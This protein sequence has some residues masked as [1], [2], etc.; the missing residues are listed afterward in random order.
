M[1][2][3]AHL[4]LVLHNHQPIGNFDGVFEAA[5]Q[6]SYLPFLD[7]FEPYDQLNISLH[8]SGPLLM[9]LAE[10]HPE[11]IDRV[12]ALVDVGRIEIIGGPQYEPIMTMLPARDR[13]G[14]IQ[15]YASW[16]RRT[17]GTHP[18]GMWTPERVWE[19]NLTSSVAQAG[20]QYTVLD[21][22]HFRAA[23]V[24]EQDMTGYFLTEDDGQTLRIF[25]GSERLRYTIPFQ[26]AADTIAYC[27]EVAERS[28]GAVLTFGD[29]GEK[30]GTWPDTKAHVYEGGWLR[31]F[32]DALTENAEWLHTITLAEAVQKTSAVGKVYLPDCSYREMTEWSLPVEQQTQLD[33]VVHD[34]EN[35]PRWPA[36]S[37]FVRGGYWRNFK[38]KYAEANEMYARMMDIS[39]RLAE[40][41]QDGVDAG[42]LASALDH[43]YRGQ[44]NCPYWHGAF[45]GI[46]LPHLR[47]AVYQ[48]LIEADNQ[49]ERATREAGASWAEATAEDYDFDGLHEVRL[50]SDKLVAIVAPG[51]GG[52]ITELDVRE[53]AHNLLAT[54]QRRPEAYHRKVLTGPSAAGDAVA[55]IHDR[56][57]FKQEGLDERLQYDR[58]P[59][60]SMMDHFYDEN[61]TLEAV[62]RGDA[63]ERGDFVD[64]PFEAK[65]RRA[66]DRVQL[67]MR[68]DGNAWGIPITI[69]KALTVAAGSDTIEITY[70]LE[71]LPP[72]NPLHFGI[73][74]NFAGLPAGADDRFFSDAEGNRL[75]QLGQ[76]QD[77]QEA[78]GLS[79]TDQWL[80]IEVGLD[81]DRPSGIWAF[82]VETVSQSEGGFELVHQSVCVQP[83][84][85]VSGDAE[86]RWAVKMW[87]RSKSLRQATAVEAASETATV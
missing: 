43:L 75:G 25:P 86:G 57:V 35:D 10:R 53:I 4:C 54:M 77:M 3:A 79:L 36:L 49:L 45:G 56:V 66:A 30:F 82:P 41:K 58:F 24:R 76:A 69:T 55:S 15:S 2:P 6:D 61:A 38:V 64:L 37:P 31:S 8:T 32:F 68:R 29:D 12:R 44:C 81:I 65:L 46:Y 23:G 60:K 42:E 62:F 39:R 21:D 48:H 84:W 78:Q 27:R 18:A 80:G 50:S 85:L 33:D 74:F 22:Y 5:Y 16:L 7:V 40:A 11:Y 51:R 26:P 63:Q 34:F 1:K 52:R 47:N 73:E 13:I 28:P 20:I 87:L 19:S 83:H 17:L 67:Q 72:G 71:N 14:Q 9:W 70:L 59:R